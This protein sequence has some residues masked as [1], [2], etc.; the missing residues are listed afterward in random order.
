MTAKVPVGGGGSAHPGASRVY[1]GWGV[2]MD[3]R[4]FVYRG[5]ASRRRP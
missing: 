3:T 1:A 4:R 2:A 5:T